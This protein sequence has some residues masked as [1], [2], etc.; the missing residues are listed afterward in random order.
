VQ[1]NSVTSWCQLPATKAPTTVDE[2][3]D[4]DDSSGDGDDDDSSD[5][6]SSLTW[7]SAVGA[8]SAL[9]AVVGLVL[10]GRQRRKSQ[11]MKKF[12]AMNTF[13]YVGDHVQ[14]IGP[15]N[16]SQVEKETAGTPNP[17]VTVPDPKDNPSI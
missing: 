5:L 8:V 13:S 2:R 10:I 7:G 11:N 6:Q 14:K 16:E 15:S 1:F 4:D 12:L 17:M 9:S 3:E